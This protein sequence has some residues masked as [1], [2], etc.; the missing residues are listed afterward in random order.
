E[1][2]PQNFRDAVAPSSELKEDAVAT[3]LTEEPTEEPTVAVEAVTQEPTEY[4]EEHTAAENKEAANTTEEP[5]PRVRTEQEK[6][7]ARRQNK[8]QS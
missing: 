1:S 8:R 6:K 3:V 4:S 7:R 5:A 2:V